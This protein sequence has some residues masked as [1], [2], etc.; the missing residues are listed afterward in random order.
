MGGRRSYGWVIVAASFVLLI[1]SFG[2]QMCFG[3]F[4]K[5]LTEQFGWSRAGV[6]GAMSLLMA[7]AGLMGVVMGRATDRYG[8]RAAIA[9]GVVIGA[10]S[11]L[12]MSKMDSLW[13]FYLLFGV[14]GGILAGC[15]YTPTVTAVS[16]WFDARNRTMAIGV[17]LL[18]PIIGQMILSPVVSAVIEGSGW[19]A[20]W[21][22][23][24]V[25]A[26]VC[27][28]PALVLMGKRP[29]MGEMAGSRNAAGR[30]APPAGRGLT[31]GETA[32]TPAFWILM[33]A[34]AVLGLGF[35]AF[36]AHVVPYATDVGI[37]TTAAALILT[38]S[39]AGGAAGTLLAGAITTRLGYRWTLLVLTALNGVALFLFIGAGSVWV[40]YFLAVILGFAFSAVVP[41]RMG[42]L[43]TLFGLRAIGTIIG[44]T[45]LSFSLGAIAGPFVAGYIFDST[46]S[47]DLA[48][49]IFGILLMIGAATLYFLR[50]PKADPAP[51]PTP[52]WRVGGGLE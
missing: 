32:K 18:G 3:L 41:V 31:A 27:G 9:P 33:V 42:V 36:T 19:R 49:V 38:V 7:V 2:T 17:A 16:K 44:F 8:A 6:S 23:L 24:A 51:D 20:A 50:V 4:V 12:L 1:G 26:F 5:P 48:F 25:V 46:A 28:L 52:I 45:S 13:E 39:S 21:V 37:S 29:A 10:L 34:G 47:Y 14:G 30:A 40:F 35:Y 43:P 15:S 11:Y 22:V